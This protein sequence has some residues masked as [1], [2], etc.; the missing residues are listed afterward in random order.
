MRRA[1]A[2]RFS[3]LLGA[4]IIAAAGLQGVA[5]LVK[6]GAGDAGTSKL[7]VAVLVSAVTGAF[8]ISALIRYLQR[9][10]TI[11][12]VIYRIAMGIALIG[13]VATDFR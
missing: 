11:V 8:A 13:L 12:F 5:H 4:P 7:L 1:E 3:F 2:A 9:A 10:S 6:E